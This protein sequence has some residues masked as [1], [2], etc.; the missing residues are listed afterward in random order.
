VSEADLAAAVFCALTG[1]PSDSGG[2]DVHAL[3]VEAGWDRAAITSHARAM[4]AD[5]RVWPH[6]VPDALRLRVGS[7]RLLA[8]VQREQQRLELFGEHAVPATRRALNADERRLLQDV[9]PHHGS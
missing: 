6:P 2:G 3:L 8:A 9:P 7:A 1:Q 5:G 4:L